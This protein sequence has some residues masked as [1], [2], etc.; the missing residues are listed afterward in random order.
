MQQCE[1]KT[2][3]P[4]TN[5][6]GPLAS[7]PFSPSVLHA[8]CTTRSQSRNGEHGE[9]PN[10]THMPTTTRP[11]LAT[12]T[13][14]GRRTRLWGDAGWGRA[15][16][17]ERN[18]N[19]TRTANNCSYITLSFSPYVSLSL[20][21]H[22]SVRSPAASCTY[23][24]SLSL[25]LCLSRRARNAVESF[26]RFPLQRTELLVL[27]SSALCT[28]PPL[29]AMRR[30]VFANRTEAHVHTYLCMYIHIHAAWL[31][32]CFVDAIWLTRGWL[33]AQKMHCWSVWVCVRCSTKS[34][35][36]T[37]HIRDRRTS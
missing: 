2:C 16:V 33:G 18:G 34:N 30:P 17:Q 7:P 22:L 6:L 35:P 29:R 3:L 4:A 1:M 9:A 12:E 24:L 28:F 11:P 14:S 37:A 23:T 13:W 20:P 10:Y 21:V 25:R 15:T 19:K 32:V 8:A 5:L 31:R 36:E 27:F 26:Y